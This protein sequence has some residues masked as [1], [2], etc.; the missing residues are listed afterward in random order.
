MLLQSGRPDIGHPV[1]LAA[2]LALVGAMGPRFLKTKKVC[3]VPRMHEGQL[4][5]VP[6]HAC[7]PLSLSCL[8]QIWPAGVMAVAGGLTA[9]Y[10]GVQ[11]RDW[12]A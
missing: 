10:E 11:T 5:L 6:Y 7:L 1:A 4:C 2:S 3:G 8:A 9:W 12:L